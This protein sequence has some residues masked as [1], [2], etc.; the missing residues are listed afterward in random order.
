[1]ILRFFQLVLYAPARDCQPNGTSSPLHTPQKVSEDPNHC[2]IMT[3]ADR[4]LLAKLWS[5]LDAALSTQRTPP[6]KP[7]LPGNILD[8]SA[9]FTVDSMNSTPPLLKS[10]PLDDPEFTAYLRLLAA[11]VQPNGQ[12]ISDDSLGCDTSTRPPIPPSFVRRSRLAFLFMFFP[13]CYS[14]AWSVSSIAPDRS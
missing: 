12:V 9:Q 4:A 1:M 7:P 11:T 6:P 13:V 5:T 8:Q 2:A 3:E 10:S 14:L